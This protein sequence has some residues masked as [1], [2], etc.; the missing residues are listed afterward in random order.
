MNSPSIYASTRGMSY[1]TLGYFTAVWERLKQLDLPIDH[2]IAQAGLKPEDLDVVNRHVYSDQMEAVLAAACQL[3]GD[4]F[5]CLKAGQQIQPMHLGALGHLLLSCS[6]PAELVELHTTYGRLVTNA[7]RVQYELDP[8][9]CKGIWTCQ[10]N[11]QRLS[12]HTIEFNLAAWSQLARS[13]VG[14]D[15][16]PSKVEFPY[17]PPND[18]SEYRKVFRCELVFDAPQVVVHFTPDLLAFPLRHAHSG[19]RTV[20]ESEL[21]RQLRELRTLNDSGAEF[22]KRVR[23]A[24]SNGIRQ[25]EVSLETTARKMNCSLRTLQ[26]QLQSRELCFRSLLDEERRALAETYIADP[27]LCL[28]DMAI[29]LGFAD[30][31]TFQRAFRRW[32]GCTPRAK[33]LALLNQGAISR[34][35]SMAPPQAA[36]LP[37]P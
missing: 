28:A 15:I 27:S 18:L 33:R 23:S 5:F 24:I 34:T 8:F 32:F 35:A 6:N 31:S 20:L 2:V 7:Y 9:H 30:Q 19:M 37:M 26:R 21:K 25:G 16:K 11:E 1:V 13:L 12:R 17:P 22:T 4:D 36:G 10:T 3:S 29:L 14:I